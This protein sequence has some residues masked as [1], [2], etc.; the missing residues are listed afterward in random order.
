MNCFLS[1]CTIIDSM[2]CLQLHHYYPVYHSFSK[3][4]LFVGLLEYAEYPVITI[5]DP[6]DQDDWNNTK[7]IT[8]LNI[9]QVRWRAS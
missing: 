6:F 4:L 3:T 8:A 7:A 5:E 9:C 2:E 1:P